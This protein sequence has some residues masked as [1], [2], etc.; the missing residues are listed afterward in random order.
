MSFT[1]TRF[2]SKQSPLSDMT[3]D[4]MLL[5][6]GE[7]PTLKSPLPP[8]QQ[9]KALT[10]QEIQRVLLTRTARPNPDNQPY[11]PTKAPAEIRQLAQAHAQEIL[12][13]KKRGKSSK[14]SHRQTSSSPQTSNTRRAPVGLTTPPSSTPKR[15]AAPESTTPS[16]GRPGP[17]KAHVLVAPNPDIQDTEDMDI[18]MNEPCAH[19]M[20]LVFE[21]ATE[22][23]DMTV[24]Y[25]M[26]CEVLGKHPN[27]PHMM[28]VYGRS[29]DP[30]DP[31]QDVFVGWGDTLEGQR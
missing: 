16:S 26:F 30:E 11:L 29:V 20:E 1:P 8:R 22:T 28:K 18:S 4:Q 27:Q 14:S 25:P 3:L 12:E 23:G 2:L 10:R 7:Q 21:V 17:G 13:A 15:P 5:I 6:H 9:G 24:A 19:V 31:D